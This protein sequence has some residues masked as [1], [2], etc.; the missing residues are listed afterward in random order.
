MIAHEM[1]SGGDSFR[2]DKALPVDL[3]GT[4]RGVPGWH[5]GLDHCGHGSGPAKQVRKS[6]GIKTVPVLHVLDEG[7]HIIALRIVRGI[8]VGPEKSQQ[9]QQ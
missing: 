5:D 1:S 3:P 6:I 4:D 9:Q 8:G 2:L 7:L